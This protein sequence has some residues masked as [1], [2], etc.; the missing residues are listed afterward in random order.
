MVDGKRVSLFYFSGTGNSWW[1]AREIEEM[2]GRAGGITTRIS[3]E[4]PTGKDPKRWV[5]ILQN[6]D[7]IGVVFPVYGSTYPRIFRAWLDALPDGE[8]MPAFVVSTMAL[9][10]GDTALHFGRKLKKM[11]YKLRQGINLRMVTNI[12][13]HMGTKIPEDEATLKK[14]FEDAR[15]KIGR[16]VEK[17]K[18]DKKW[19][20]RRDPLSIIGALS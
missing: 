20:Q 8:G 17:I 3:L 19:K 14:R 7:I 16:L 18:R 5:P 12:H 10:S 4:S 9:F 1:A 13:G 6:A 11:G 2:L 15:E